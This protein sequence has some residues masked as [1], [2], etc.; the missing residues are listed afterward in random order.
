MARPLSVICDENEHFTVD[1]MCA[2]YS[3]LNRHGVTRTNIKAI[4]LEWERSAGDGMNELRRIFF[5]A[6]DFKGELLRIFN[7][8]TDILKATDD[9]S[10]V[11]DIEWFKDSG[12]K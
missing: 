8:E 4:G 7:T 3:A 1:N 11:I 12:K 6:P 5:R 9:I 2:L 10:E